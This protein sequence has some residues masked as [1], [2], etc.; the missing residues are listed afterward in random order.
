MPSF[1]R[2]TGILLG[3]TSF[4]S[5]FHLRAR[6]K[7]INSFLIVLIPKT[8]DASTINNFWPI[9]LCNVVYKIISKLLESKIIPLLH[10]INISQSIHLHSRKMDS[11]ES[12]GSEEMCH[13]FKTRKIESG[14][15][16]LK[17]YLQKAYDRM[18][19]SFLKVVMLR[20]GF[21][22]TF[23]NWSISYVSTVSFEVLVC[24]WMVQNQT[25]LGQVEDC[26]KVTHCHPI[27]LS[28]G[29]KFCQ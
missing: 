1:I 19:W 23:V 18:N 16:A 11:W 6:P 10:K 2:N 4:T 17:L 9:S 13:S 20:F 22:E 21:N 25:N 8:Q 5:F 3:R 27:Y 24:W 14:L 29:K 28:L 12:G 26:G 15:M 7:E